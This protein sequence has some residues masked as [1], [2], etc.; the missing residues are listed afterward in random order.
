MMR[1]KPYPGGK[2]DESA[3]LDPLR[4]REG[5]PRSDDVGSR[6]HAVGAHVQSR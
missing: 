4:E 1:A 6:A 2:T 5:K 3:A